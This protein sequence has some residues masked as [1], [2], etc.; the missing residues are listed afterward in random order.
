MNYVLV[1]ALLDIHLNQLL[2]KPIAIKD[3]LF[4]T[5]NSEQLSAYICTAHLLS[6]G[7]L[8][9]RL[10]TNNTPCLYRLEH[11]KHPDQIPI[12]TIDF[13][14]EVQAFLTATWLL[15]DNSANCELA[16][17][18]GMNGQHTHSHSNSLALHYCHHSGKKFPLHISIDELH[19]ICQNHKCSFQGIREAVRPQHTAHQAQLSR[20]DRGMLFLQQARSSDDLGQK[21]SNYCSLFESILS[22]S[23]AEL[24]H[25]LAERI[26]FFTEDAA[27]E[28][29]HLFRE[30]KRAYSIRSKIVHGDTLSTSTINKLIDSASICDTTAR[31]LIARIISTPHLER[32]LSSGKNAE[33]E[34][35][36]LELL[37]GLRQSAL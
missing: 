31:R 9:A 5:N 19:S 18:F 20:L 37:F 21:I 28:R 13:L 26:A 36:A 25:Q 30:I 15:R 14:R 6:A 8:E 11:G 2:T 35:F 3:G 4:F 16:F 10:L 27:T 29:L 1:T 12:D 17:A 34:D 22:T 23:A 24:S 33:I 32:L 7:S